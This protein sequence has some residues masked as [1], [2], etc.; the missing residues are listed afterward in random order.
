MPD[1]SASARVSSAADHFAARASIIALR[2]SASA[3]SVVPG[4]A[5]ASDAYSADARSGFSARSYAKASRSWSDASFESMKLRFA[6]SI[7]FTL[8]AA[9]CA[10]SNSMRAIGSSASAR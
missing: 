1:A 4:K 7:V 8:S 3:A 9:F 5:F 6:V 2:Y 10:A